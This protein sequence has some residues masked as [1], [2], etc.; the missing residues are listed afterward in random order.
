MKSSPS[1][2]L[3][4]KLTDIILSEEIAKQRE[5]QFEVFVN[6][7]VKAEIE[8]SER[9]GRERKE[10]NREN[11]FPNVKFNPIIGSIINLIDAKVLETELQLGGIKLLRKIVE[12]ENP[13]SVEPAADWDSEEWADVKQNI[14]LKQ[15]KLVDRGT[16]PFLCKL[17]SDSEEPEVQMECLLVCIA[18]LIGGNAKSQD[19]FFLYMTKED[20]ENRL[21]DTIQKMLRRTFESTKKYLTEKNAYLEMK[22]KQK[23][24]AERKQQEKD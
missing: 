21:L 6:W 1:S 3:Q 2:Q 12:V 8:I 20:T 23:K 15:N 11:P 24:T 17:I 22:L 4:L 7:V 13:G 19:A 18:L 14:K 9:F 10:G 5:K 16:I